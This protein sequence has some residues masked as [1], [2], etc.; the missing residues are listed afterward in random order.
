[1]NKQDRELATLVPAPLPE[2]P[3]VPAEDRVQASS[4][5]F[6]L[7]KHALPDMTPEQWEAWE[8]YRCGPW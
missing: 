2:Q 4:I 6:P 5:P 8:W 1:M 7:D 3:Q